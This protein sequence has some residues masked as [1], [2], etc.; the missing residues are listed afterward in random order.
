MSFPIA[1]RACGAR[2]KLPPGCSKK[3]ARCPKCNAS[4]NL[5]AARDA[6]AYQPGSVSTVTIPAPPGLPAPSKPGQSPPAKTTAP[7]PAKNPVPATP[8]TRPAPAAKSPPPPPRP[9]VPPAPAAARSPAPPAV[10]RPAVPPAAPPKPAAVPPKPANP[11]PAREEDPLPY[12]DLNPGRRAKTPLQLDDSP[13][14]APPPLPPAAPPFRTPARVTADSAKLFAG[15]CE[16]VLVPHGMFLESVPYRPFLYAPVGSQTDPS[17]GR[18]VI[19]TLPDGRGVTVEFAGRH[20]ARIAGDVAAFLARERGLPDHREYRRNPTWLLWLALIF[21][22]GLAVGPIVLSQTTDL[23]IETGLMIGGGFAGAGLLVNAVIVLFSRMGVFGKVFTMTT[24]GA[25][26]TGIFLFAATAYLAG[27]KHEAEQANQGGT[28]GT[29]APVAPGTEPP[30]P[31]DPPPPDPRRGLPT[32]V[33]LAYRDGF[34]RFE[35]GPDDV[36]AL[37]V[38]RDG[39]VM[40]VGYKNGTSRVW[41]FDNIPDDPFEPGPRAEGPVTRIQFDAASAIAYLSCAGGTVAAYWA[42]PPEVPVKIPGEPFA[43]HTF[44]GDGGERFAVFRP[45]ALPLRYVPTERLKGGKA[46][47]KARKDFDVLAPKDEVQPIDVKA[48]LAPPGPKP[49]FLAWHPTGKLLGGLPDGSI[50]SWGDV[51]PRSTVISRDHKAPVRA[52]AASP[53]TWDFATADDKGVVGLWP[54]R[55]MTPRVFNGATAGITHM[56]FSPAGRFLALADAE[57]QVWLWDLWNERSI[58]KTKR[59]S[60]VRALAYGPSDDLLILSDGKSIDLW[61][62][63]ELAKQP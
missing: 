58:L 51:G 11:P 55:A 46:D 9:V 25:L 57:N 37:G 8:A 2:L 7:A 31:G 30:K 44:P 39:S 24:V 52:W 60:P 45:G 36:T 16:V 62:V 28:P 1:C 3:K 54:D 18:S 26:V 14:A 41:R 43:A 27:R 10:A 59:P 49:T 29:A 35:A 20:A 33:D 22:L 21:S 13:G 56:A 17:G 42:A 53:N 34:Y 32:T 50:L 19:V 63:P 4:M 40:L 5:V 38:V 48:Q 15:P 47:P 12:A 23:G 61:H 6:S